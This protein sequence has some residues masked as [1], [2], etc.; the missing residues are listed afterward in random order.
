[1]RP[2]ILATLAAFALALTGALAVSSPASAV[3]AC[4]NDW[5]C[6]YN[7]AQVGTNYNEAREG[8]DT[9]SGECHKFPSASNNTTSYVINKT[10]W[11][12]RMY[13]A[14]NCTGAYGTLYADSSGGTPTFNNKGS[15]YKRINN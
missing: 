9:S 6:F 2:R 14:N 7:D 1:M 8:E 3:K 15:S 11:T 13:D 4:P 12:W 5:I 10:N